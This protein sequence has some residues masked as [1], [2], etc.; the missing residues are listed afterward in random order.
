MGG[1]VTLDAIQEAARAIR[2]VVR[3]TPL[4]DVSRPEEPPLLLKCENLQLGG[5]FKIRGALYM[6]GRLRSEASGR[7][8]VITYSSGNHGRAVALASRLVGIAAVVVMPKTAPAIKVEAVRDLGAEVILEGSTSEERKVRAETEAERR[9]LTMVPPFDHEWII[10]GQGTIGLE[11]LEQCAELTEVYV[12]VGGGGLISGIAAAIKQLR[13]AVRVIGVEPSGAAGMTAS[14]QAGRPVTLAK[15]MSIADG[16]LPLRPGDLTF[17]HVREYVDALVTIEDGELI[18]TA[19]W[20]FGEAKLVVEPS[21][22]AGL[23]ALQA[24][25]KRQAPRRATE[26]PAAAVISGGNIAAAN[27]AAMIDGRR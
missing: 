19:G 5:A 18:S 21:G 10:A 16:L 13:P 17:E 4:V 15:T 25:R 8:G 20:L 26:G 11:L 23:A 9:G 1:L 22:A 6:I 7:A 27:L 2:G 24:A 12:P 3:F 14:L